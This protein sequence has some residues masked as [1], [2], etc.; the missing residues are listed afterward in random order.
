M[1]DAPAGGVGRCAVYGMCSMRGVHH[2][3]SH[4]PP[5]MPANSS[6]HMPSPPVCALEPGLG[7]GERQPRPVAGA[8]VRLGVAGKSWAWSPQVV[9]IGTIEG[10]TGGTR[11][12]SHSRRD[13]CRCRPQA[14]SAADF[15]CQLH[16]RKDMPASTPAWN[17]S[18]SSASQ[19]PSPGPYK[20]RCICALYVLPEGLVNVPNV[21]LLQTP[22]PHLEPHPLQRFPRKAPCG[23]SCYANNMIKCTM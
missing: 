14:P 22:S 5:H 2:A 1:V 3:A 13:P 6:L 20:G 15:S 10:G 21:P 16:Q 23:P 9:H 19:T 17:C 7:A 11:G 8:H 18:R 12:G 4:Q